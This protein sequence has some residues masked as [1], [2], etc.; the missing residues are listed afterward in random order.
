MRGE[1]SSEVIIRVD[2]PVEVLHSLANIDAEIVDI[3]TL[4]FEEDR[5]KVPCDAVSV[6]LVEAA[7]FRP[8]STGCQLLLVLPLEHCF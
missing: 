2:L 5:Q 6:F 8:I 7:E 3:H 4:A 1:A